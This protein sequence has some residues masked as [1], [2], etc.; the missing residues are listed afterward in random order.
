MIKL[1]STHQ[2]GAIDRNRSDA[3]TLV[4]ILAQIVIVALGLFTTFSRKTTLS[5]GCI[6]DPKGLLALAT[7]NTGTVVRIHSDSAES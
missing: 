7:S 1:I 4:V 5:Q 3:I 6:I 2:V